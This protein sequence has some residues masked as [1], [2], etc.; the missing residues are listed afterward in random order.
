MS[1]DY[2]I[3][4]AARVIWKAILL[5][6]FFSTTEN[7]GWNNTTMRQHSMC[8]ALPA[9]YSSSPFWR[10]KPELEKIVHTTWCYFVSK[11]SRSLPRAP[12]GD[13]SHHSQSR[14]VQESAILRGNILSPLCAF[15]LEF[16][17]LKFQRIFAA[18]TRITEKVF[19]WSNTSY[20]PVE[21][22]ICYRATGTKS[23]MSTAWVPTSQ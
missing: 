5:L 23:S 4:K 6:K 15:Q 7:C 17:L 11:Y 2:I 9:Q 16:S 3:S 20:I 1:R 10:L 21:S 8:H 13:R 19:F 14:F 18:N 12:L 22:R